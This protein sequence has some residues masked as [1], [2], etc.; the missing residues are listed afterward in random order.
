MK[1]A[2]VGA[3]A[4]G[5]VYGGLFA[6]SG[7]EVW[8]VDPWR[9]H[10]D[11]VRRDGLHVSG[12]SG[13]RVVRPHATSEPAELGPC[14]LIVIATKMRDVE[15]AARSL[16][17]MRGNDTAVLAIQNGL[18]NQEILTRVL[19]GNDYLLGIAGGFGASNPKPGYV[20]HNG[21]DRVNVAEAG[22]GLTDRLERVARV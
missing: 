3:G 17:P 5:S 13:E 10:I 4:M 12:A 9:E 15:A 19:A 16:A 1:I 21:W 22:G 18:G 7:H 8:L 6:A 2:I 14:E 20:H 11:A